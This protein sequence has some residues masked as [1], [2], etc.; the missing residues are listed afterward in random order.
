M[1]F[2]SVKL[3]SMDVELISYL[4]ADLRWSDVLLSIE[5]VHHIHFLFL[6]QFGDDFDAIPL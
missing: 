1:F 2:E 6:N 5:R 3:T 4:P